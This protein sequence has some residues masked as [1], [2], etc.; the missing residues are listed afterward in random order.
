MNER[1]WIKRIADIEIERYNSLGWWLLLH[2]GVF[3][4]LL[5]FIPE[6][7]LRGAWKDFT[8]SYSEEFITV[9]LPT[10]VLVA[11]KIATNLPL[12]FIYKHKIPFFEQYRINPEEPWPW[13]AD[14]E[15]WNFLFRETH[16]LL[17]F[18]TFVTF[19]MSFVYFRVID[20]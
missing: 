13:E 9:V 17:A 3:S 18:N 20:G 7:L 15:R 8:S 5:K 12:Y 4:L 14:I 11:I 1:F 19:A 16:I 2:L 10:L 6:F